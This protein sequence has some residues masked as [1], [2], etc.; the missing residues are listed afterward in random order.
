MQGLVNLIVLIFRTYAR[1]QQ[2]SNNQFQYSS[3]SEQKKQHLIKPFIMCAS[4]GYILECYTGF[5]A[6]WN[7]SDIM[8]HILETDKELI[9]ICEPKKTVFILDRGKK[10][11][12]FRKNISLSLP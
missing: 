6:N 11:F 9:R 5:P 3:W 12:N 10:N 1:C 8:L 4:N 7:D 2:S